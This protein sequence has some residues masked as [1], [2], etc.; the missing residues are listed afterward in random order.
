MGICWYCYWGW[1]KPIADIYSRALTELD[2]HDFPLHYGPAHV[3]WEDENFEC[4]EVCLE[5]F[6]KYK[7]DIN[8]NDLEIV[9]KSLEELAKIPIVERDIKPDDY[10]G[11]HP[12]LYPP[13]V[14][15]VK[16]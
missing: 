8:D 13:T 14:E 7:G 4:A 11:L 5:D 9:R 1:P 10:D 3:V 2:G 12:E 16:V 6:D 15:M